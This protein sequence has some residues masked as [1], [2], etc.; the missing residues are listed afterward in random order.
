MSLPVL[1]KEV[2]RPTKAPLDQTPDSFD[3]VELAAV[4]RQEELKEVVRE[5]LLDQDGFVH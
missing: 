3:R 5:L 1:P 2:G 4:R